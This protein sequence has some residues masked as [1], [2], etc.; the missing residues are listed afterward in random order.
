MDELEGLIHFWKVVL[1]YDKWCMPPSTIY[2]IESTIR[3]LEE[4]KKSKGV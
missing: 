1:F 4:L 3:Y 2:Q